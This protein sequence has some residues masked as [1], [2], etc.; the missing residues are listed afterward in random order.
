V[1]LLLSSRASVEA[2]NMPS[3]VDETMS[4]DVGSQEE[5]T[6]Q[7]ERVRRE[8]QIYHLDAAELL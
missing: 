3:A 4:I 2:S 5:A 6:M 1:V 7:R 8:R